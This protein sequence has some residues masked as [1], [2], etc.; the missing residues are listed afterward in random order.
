MVGGIA[1]LVLAGAFGF[2]IARQGAG[3]R[4]P[5]PD[6]GKLGDGY[7]PDLGAGTSFGGA[8]AG[9]GAGAGAN[10]SAG[11]GA[12]GGGFQG[13]DQGI[14][15]S[16][17]RFQSGPQGFQGSVQGSQDSIHGVGVGERPFAPEMRAQW[18]GGGFNPA[19]TGP[20]TAGAVAAAGHYR[21]QNQE[22]PPPSEPFLLPQSISYGP[23]VV[24][25]TAGA[26]RP[27]PGEKVRTNYRF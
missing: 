27:R 9:S 8:N 4:P 22:M 20:Y 24:A 1:G 16:I 2:F 12:N 13:G 7:A 21:E 23:H 6:I 26:R 17:H 10:G 15:G 3:V 11:P 18:G 25:A 5:L 19:Y 14:Q